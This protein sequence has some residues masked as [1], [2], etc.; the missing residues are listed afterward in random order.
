MWWRSGGDGGRLVGDAIGCTPG[1]IGGS[2]RNLL[3][4]HPSLTCNQCPAAQ[5]RVRAQ[6]ARRAIRGPAGRIV[7]QVVRC[8]GCEGRE[9]AHRWLRSGQVGAGRGNRRGSGSNVIDARQKHCGGTG[10]CGH[11]A[12]GNRN[13]ALCLHAYC[14]TVHGRKR[15]SGSALCKLAVSIPAVGP[16]LCA[17]LA[18]QRPS[19]SPSSLRLSLSLPASIQTQH[20]SF[21]GCA[22]R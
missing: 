13:R 2:A 22:S 12:L 4:L 19:A 7:R 17:T 6:E 10:G 21:T 15:A 9:G 18:A 11:S 14:H 20:P 5:K 1:G 8:E 16:A 3:G